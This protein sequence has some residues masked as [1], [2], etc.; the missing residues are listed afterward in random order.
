[1][2]AYLAVAAALQG[3]I[4]SKTLSA[5]EAGQLAVEGLHKQADARRQ[6]KGWSDE[7]LRAE[8]TRAVSNKTKLIFQPGHGVYAEY[9]APDGNLGMWYPKNVN[10][11]KGSWGV[12][13]VRGKTRACF[14]YRNAVN[15]ITHEYEPT[16][17]VSPEQTIGS[18]G[19]IQSWDGDVFGL[20]SDKIPYPK[21]NLDIPSP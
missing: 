3:A 13:K 5:A 6:I 12:R 19:V 20:M 10:V 8:L 14:S 21:G 2:L 9:T 16:E 1:M 7:Q 17:C 4:S 15:P 18:A 11:V